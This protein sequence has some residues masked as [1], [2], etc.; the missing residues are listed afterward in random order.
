M[1][2]PLHSID[3]I[4]G[5]PFRHEH[6]PHIDYLTHTM[7]FTFYGQQISLTSTSQDES[8]PLLSHTQV[9]RALR[10]DNKAYMV[11]VSEVEEEQHPP[12]S[13]Q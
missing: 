1:V 2:A 9:K 12:L 13:P 3:I 4:L 5:I 11:Y 7:K 10:K 8:L 6:N